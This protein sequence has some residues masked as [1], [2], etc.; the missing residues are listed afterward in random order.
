M[1]MLKKKKRTGPT[2]KNKQGEYKY[3]PTEQIAQ[4]AIPIPIQDKAKENGENN[5]HERANKA[6]NHDT[7]GNKEENQTHGNY[8]HKA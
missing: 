7:K 5:S 6:E 1:M 4:W 8:V 2:Q 3:L